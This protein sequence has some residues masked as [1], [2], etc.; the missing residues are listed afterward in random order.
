MLLIFAIFC[1]SLVAAGRSPH[2][3]YVEELVR[4][5]AFGARISDNILEDASLDVPELVRKYNY[6]LE[7][8]FIMTQDGYILGLHRIPHGRDNNN[9]RG[10]K[11]VVFVMHGLLGSSA[12]WVLMGPGTALAYILAEEGFDVW[13]GNA[14][15]NYYSRRHL[16]LNPDAENDNSFWRFSLDEIGN[17]DLSA[18]IDYILLATGRSGLHYVGMS[19]GTTVY[20]IMNSLRPDY[21]EK[22]LSMHALA[23]VA[24]QTQSRGTLMDALAPI[25]A[26]ALSWATVLGFGEMFPKSELLAWAGQKLCQD[27]AV[28]QPICSSIFFLIGGWNMD[29]HNATMIPVMLAH[30]PAGAG[31]RQFAHFAQNV[32]TKG[33]RRYDY[34]VLLNLAAYGTAAPPSY[35]LSKITNPVFLHYSEGDTR[36]DL[37]DVDRLYNEL[38]GPKE[39]ILVSQKTFSHIDFMWGTN[40]R[41]YVFDRV[42]RDI[43][44]IDNS[45]K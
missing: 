26:D 31:L 22:I 11:P 12:D 36:V 16:T 28:F 39:K 29:Q 9:V 5:N 17:L 6:P 38:G 23:P 13:L 37:A 3:D 42:I 32:A 20:F 4:Q 44:I 15:G 43:R 30:T 33:F 40:A 25:A 7:E 19:Q 45:N 27:E 18:S 21:S 1:V 2:A 24:Y 34:G 10:N 41:F 8:H 35:N 14:R